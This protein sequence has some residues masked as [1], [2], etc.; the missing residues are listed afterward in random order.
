MKLNVQSGAGMN[1]NISCRE[2]GKLSCN[3]LVPQLG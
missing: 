1:K 3:T 2:L